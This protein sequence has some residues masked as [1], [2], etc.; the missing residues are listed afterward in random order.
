MA[1]QLNRF[2]DVQQAAQALAQAVADDL[3]RALEQR[4]RALLLVSGGKSPV[5]FFTALAAQPLSWDRVDV[6]L[7][8]ERAVPADHADSN[9]NM[10]VA[11]LLQGAAGAARWLP[12]VTA[13]AA[14]SDPLALAL[15]AAAAA[16]ANPA[17]AQPAAI[18]LG[19][20]TDGHTASL[21][22]DALQW[23]Q[24]CT[25]QQR[26]VAIEPK[27]APHARISLSLHALIAQRRCYLWSGG[28]EKL[29]VLTRIERTVEAALRDDKRD[30]VAEAGPIALLLAEPAVELR[31]FHYDG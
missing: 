3:R 21:F 5:P 31:C 20:G 26:Y 13:A 6:S 17:L 9:G 10:V 23:G 30:A 14:G 24:A 15:A 12:L 11:H 28:D 27:R 22:D 8:D 16:E 29:A 1:L 7:V 19:M 4:E 18:V 25:T 2:P